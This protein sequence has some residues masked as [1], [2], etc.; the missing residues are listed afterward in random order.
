M[1]RV[2]SPVN[3][4]EAVDAVRNTEVVEEHGLG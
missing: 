3:C 1:L 4:M 2:N